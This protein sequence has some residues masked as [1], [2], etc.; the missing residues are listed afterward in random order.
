MR[1]MP[2]ENLVFTPDHDDAASVLTK[3]VRI[4]LARSRDYFIYDGTYATLYEVHP[5][6]TEGVGLSTPVAFKVFKGTDEETWELAKDEYS[7][8]R[9]LDGLDGHAPRAFVLGAATASSWSTRRHPA[10]A[11]EY[12]PGS[13][14]MEFAQ[15][16][17]GD[18]LSE[19]HVVDVFQR[20]WA[21]SLAVFD[22]VKS[23]MRHGDLSYTNV[24]LSKLED[25]NSLGKEYFAAAIDFG[26]AAKRRDLSSYDK[27]GTDFFSAP[28]LLAEGDTFDA[29]RG[30]A[31][32]DVYSMGA[33]ALY[34][35]LRPAFA[36]DEDF[37]GYVQQEGALPDEWLA[38]W[39][40]RS[41]CTGKLAEMLALVISCC[42]RTEPMDRLAVSDVLE[43]FEALCTPARRT[44]GQLD[45]LKRWLLHRGVADRFLLA[46]SMERY[47]IRPNSNLY[48]RNDELELMATRLRHGRVAYL[49]GFG[50]IGKTTLAFA[51]AGRAIND[52]SF[53]DLGIKRVYLLSFDTSM[54][55]TLAAVGETLPP[56]L[57]EA[58]AFAHADSQ[59]AALIGLQ[60]L[61]ESL[62]RDALLILDNLSQ[63]AHASEPMSDPLLAHMV[64][65]GT[66]RLV[67]TS[68]SIPAGMLSDCEVVVAGMADDAL[69]HVFISQ[70]RGAPCERDLLPRL[71]RAVGR[72]TLAVKIVGGLVGQS[73]GMLSLADVLDVLEAGSL[74]NK[75]I[76]EYEVALDGSQDTD[77]IRGHVLK[78]LSLAGLTEDE[79]RMLSM[80]LLIPGSG[81]SLATLREALRRYEPELGKVFGSLQSRGW[82]ETIPDEG[83]V[84]LH[85]LVRDVCLE[86][87]QVLPPAVT[88][89]QFLDVLYANAC[90]HAE[91][92]ELSYMRDLEGVLGV[93]EELFAGDVRDSAMAYLLQQHAE[94][95]RVL[96]RPMQEIEVLTRLVRLYEKMTEDQEA[97]DEGRVTALVDALYHLCAAQDDLGRYG[98]AVQSATRALRLLGWQTGPSDDAGEGT[99]ES[100]GV[101][102][103]SVDDLA[104][105]ARLL[106]MRGYASHDLWEYG[107]CGEEELKSAL[108]DKRAALEIVRSIGCDP[109]QMAGILYT[110]AY[111]EFCF[112]EMKERAIANEEEAI[113][114]LR[115]CPH[116]PNREREL[117]LATALNSLGYFLCGPKGVYNPDR[118]EES[119]DLKEEAIRIRY[120]FHDYRHRT[121]ARSHNNIA[122]SLKEMGEPERALTH[123]LIALKIRDE[124]FTLDDDNLSSLIDKNIR[125]LQ[126][127]LGLSDADV[128]LRFE[129]LRVPE[130]YER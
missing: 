63:A 10:I 117:L 110:L 27:L 80:L 121:I 41:E 62:G 97:L 5:V 112:D 111:T 45:E 89:R 13:S 115:S 44:A 42:M 118:L 34:Q 103:D 40:N 57:N 101:V 85:P 94:A 32:A 128:R 30:R 12:L 22:L 48:G 76:D 93:A 69:D 46:S 83:R 113:E 130:A 109:W 6:D 56:M 124:R 123:A 126:E 23:G 39:M 125:E 9:E 114:L 11:Q 79:C 14:V 78:L 52:R 64:G 75:M 2:A 71:Y 91:R 77:T 58:P 59:R 1:G 43:A 20:M 17:A 108:I 60:A 73:A 19:E 127:R 24:L 86:V 37:F 106:A 129:A 99:S 3:P 51:F 29:N 88:A 90:W 98:E 72:N 74:G 107:G 8:L 81:I 18:P 16:D 68:R 122:L 104:L 70:L 116:K 21:I 47:R 35:F 25:S 84:Y 92:G 53:S 87:D 120:R 66:Y 33:L 26:Q 119:L 82:I 96:G 28:E 100:E 105:I 36:S 65:S 67:I 15:H 102:I 55:K 4:R 50:G 54:D 7:I 61:E 31:S 95:L 38:A 49:R